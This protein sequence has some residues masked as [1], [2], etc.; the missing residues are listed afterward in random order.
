MTYSFYN[1]PHRE[2]PFKDCQILAA[3]EKPQPTQYHYVKCMRIFRSGDR[4]MPTFFQP[5]IQLF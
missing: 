1:M 4:K 5:K 3:S 2:Q